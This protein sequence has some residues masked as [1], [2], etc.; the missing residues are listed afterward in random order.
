MIPAASKARLRKAGIEK[1]ANTVVIRRPL[2][3]ARNRM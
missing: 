1:T 2:T 3:A